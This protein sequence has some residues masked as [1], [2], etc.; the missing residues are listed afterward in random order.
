MTT[1][2]SAGLR[3]AAAA[4]AIAML[5]SAYMIFISAPADAVEGDVQR[6]FYL[7]V[8]CAIAAYAAFAV[9]LVA[10][11]AH[12][13][14]R[15]PTPDRV[16]RAAARVGLVFTSVTLVMGSIWARP[17]W[18]TFWTWDARLTTTLMLWMIYAGYL[19]VRRLA[20][21]GLAP[22]LAAVVGIFGF[23]DV[24]VSYFSVTWWRTQHP[25]PVLQTSS[26][27]QLPPEMLLTFGITAV[28]TLLLAGVYL[29]ARIRIEGAEDELASLRGAV[30]PGPRP[31][32]A[33]QTPDP[34]VVS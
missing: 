34:G 27:P 30:A 1:D 8:A 13:W 3:A 20:S 19:L 22:R 32:A 9:V 6:I 4:A 33:S 15:S 18:G 25:G 21:P 10:S 29:W 17:I 12:L 16:A 24:P 7:H 31:A 11:V 23:V 14:R 2:R 5:L 26:G 28:A